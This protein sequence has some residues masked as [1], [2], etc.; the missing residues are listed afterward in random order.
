MDWT[1]LQKQ[2]W[3]KRE[4][5]ANGI[6]KVFYLSPS[7]NGVRR[8]IKAPEDLEPNDSV[9]SSILFP[10]QNRN[11]STPLSQPVTKNKKKANESDILSQTVEKET[12]LMSKMEA[13]ANKLIIP[14]NTETNYDEMMKNSVEKL[15]ELCSDT[16]N[17]SIDARQITVDLIFAMGA[18]DNPFKSFPWD[19]S[20]NIFSEIM[21][22]Y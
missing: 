13:A 12:L 4:F 15:S 3:V 16:S 17:Y 21:P 9:I 22:K 2:G 19:V 10:S 8:K 14:P 1:V 7:E 11:N 5:S 20:L 6:T 18:D